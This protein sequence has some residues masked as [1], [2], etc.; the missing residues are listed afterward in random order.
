MLSRLRLSLA[1]ASSMI[2]ALVLASPLAAVSSQQPVTFAQCI[3]EAKLVAL[4]SVAGDSNSGFI[5]TVEK[6]LKGQAGVQLVY[7]GPQLITALEPG[8]TEVVIAFDDP[9][10]LDF[11]AGTTV[12]HVASDG[13]VDPEGYQ[14]FPGLPPTLTAM[15]AYFAPPATSTEDT[16]SR[17]GSG[18]PLAP[19]LLAI[20][21][22]LAVVWRLVGRP[23][24][25]LSRQQPN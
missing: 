7:P 4:V 5:V 23:K 20:S 13:R 3:A 14:Q 17:Q 19:A 10:T 9:T 18:F 16:P 1:V 6:V 24:R 25:V 12:W 11:R 8:W 22:S 2:L 15:L 21:G